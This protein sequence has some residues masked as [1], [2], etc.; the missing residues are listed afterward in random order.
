[1]MPLIEDLELCFLCG[2]FNGN[3]LLPSSMVGVDH[4]TCHVQRPS[5]S[6][7]FILFNFIFGCGGG[8]SLG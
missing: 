4:H 8:V 2:G 5:S 6:F 1:M 7:F 3:I